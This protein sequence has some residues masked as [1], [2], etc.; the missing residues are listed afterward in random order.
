MIV[1]I[2]HKTEVLDE[3][4]L[5]LYAQKVK[6]EETTLCYFVNIEALGLYK[7]LTFSLVEKENQRVYFS[8]L[9]SGKIES[10]FLSLSQIIQIPVKT[11]C[12]L[13]LKNYPGKSTRD[14][15]N[16]K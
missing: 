12:K 13:V 5:E 11:A 8:N 4:P 2:C 6:V 9:N 7:T 14:T 1:V 16:S 10:K 3:A 15:E